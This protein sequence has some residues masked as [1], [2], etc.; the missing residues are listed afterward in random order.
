MYE[1]TDKRNE[2]SVSNLH[3]RL[4]CTMNGTRCFNVNR[5]FEKVEQH[6]PLPSPVRQAFRHGT[7]T[8]P[9]ELEN[10]RTTQHD[11]CTVVP[12]LYSSLTR[13]KS[14]RPFI[15]R[16]SQSI[17]E[18]KLCLK[19]IVQLVAQVTEQEKYLVDDSKDGRAFVHAQMLEKL[20]DIWRRYKCRVHFQRHIH[21]NVTDEL[22]ISDFV[23][24]VSYFLIS[25]Y[26]RRLVVSNKYRCRIQ[27][28]KLTIVQWAF[29]ITYITY[30]GRL[31]WQRPLVLFVIT[32]FV[33][34]DC[35]LFV[36]CW[37][38]HCSSWY[39]YVHICSLWISLIFINLPLTFLVKL[40]LLWINAVHVSMWQDNTS[41]KVL[42]CLQNYKCSTFQW[43]T[44]AVHCIL[45]YDAIDSV[46]KGLTELKL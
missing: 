20:V 24:A 12:M 43:C 8:V 21:C 34:F 44:F 15:E 9:V 10:W 3:E 11:T 39:V 2:T 13:G 26:F 29:V 31:F 17:I 1:A 18:G 35:F 30:S 33:L 7:G 23:S 4:R 22:R 40:M 16:L 38:L 5:C 27:Q 19:F 25:N 42:Q 37:L 46:K 41:F 14:R 6:I 32:V 28:K 36:F 45:L